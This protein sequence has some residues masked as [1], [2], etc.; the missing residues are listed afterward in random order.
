MKL[1]ELDPSWKN[2]ILV[3]DCPCGKCGGKIRVRTSQATGPAQTGDGPIWKASG[4]FPELTLSPSL[5]TGCWHGFII[6]GE[7]TACVT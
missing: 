7:A 6:K 4:E 5:N 1:T 2:G 3:I